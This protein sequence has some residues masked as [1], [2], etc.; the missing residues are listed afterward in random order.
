MKNNFFYLFFFYLYLFPNFSYTQTVIPEGEI[1][2]IWTI[3]GSPYQIEGN[4]S[5]PTDSTLVIEPE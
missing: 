2:G 5:V 1:S 4:V 3:D